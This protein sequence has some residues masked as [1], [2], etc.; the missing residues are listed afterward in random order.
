MTT[1][2]L[3]LNTRHGRKELLWSGFHEQRLPF[4][5]FDRFFRISYTLHFLGYL[6]QFYIEMSGQ[7]S[8]RQAAAS[9]YAA[10]MI[11]KGRGL[12]RQNAILAVDQGEVDKHP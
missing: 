4:K 11:V 12:S 2:L 3:C 9:L 5:T 10:T 7:V 8:V 1:Y 6:H